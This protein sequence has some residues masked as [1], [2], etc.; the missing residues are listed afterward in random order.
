[1]QFTLHSNA[2]IIALLCKYRK[3]PRNS[4]ISAW[5]PVDTLLTVRYLTIKAHDNHGLSAFNII[6]GG[7]QATAAPLRPR[8]PRR[9]PYTL[10]ESFHR[11]P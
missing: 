11:V 3:C 6:I 1:M 4:K 8:L 2:I 7:K 10:S 9:P 5:T